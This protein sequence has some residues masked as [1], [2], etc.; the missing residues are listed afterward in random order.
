M[1]KLE[2]IEGI[3]PAFAEKLAAVG[4]ASC[5]ALLE[6][7]ATAAGRQALGEATGIGP[8]LLLRWVNHADLFRISGIGPQY[9]ELLEVAGVDTVAELAQ[10]VPANLHAKL[11]EVQ[12]QKKLTGRVPAASSVA[13]WVEQ[14]G[15]LPRVV[16]Y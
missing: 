3:G 5:E 8:G 11:V 16:T 13:D 4:I 15:Q 9:A 14:A 2:E 7:G 6:Q 10:R 1:T 12:A